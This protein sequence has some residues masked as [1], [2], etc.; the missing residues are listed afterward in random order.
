MSRNKRYDS[1]TERFIRGYS[2]LSDIIAEWK[3][4]DG[5][6]KTW[7]YPDVTIKVKPVSDE[8]LNV[9]PA[10]Y[11]NSN[12]CQEFQYF[13]LAD[14]G[15]DKIIKEYP[16][17]DGEEDKTIREILLSLKD[18]GLERVTYIHRINSV[19]V[20]EYGDWQTTLDISICCPRNTD[21]SFRD[22]VDNTETVKMVVFAEDN[23]NQIVHLER[24]TPG[25]AA[26]ADLAF[27]RQYPDVNIKM[28]VVQEV[29]KFPK[30]GKIAKNPLKT[31][32]LVL[33]G[34]IDTE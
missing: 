25:H 9:V 28:L 32:T 2:E 5:L 26:Y 29:K 21:L 7:R 10:K 19:E 24:T 18:S 8:F 4:Q 15:K 22:M 23:P 1:T 17:E 31:Y 11:K 6:K 14:C 20:W 34:V 33:L 27:K 13:V 3:R 16:F 30:K 12:T